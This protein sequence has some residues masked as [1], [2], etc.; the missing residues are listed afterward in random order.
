LS[1]I[2]HQ[3]ADVYAALCR[4]FPAV[5]ECKPLCKSAAAKLRHAAVELGLNKEAAYKIVR[6]HQTSPACLEA[7]LADGAIACSL[8]GTPIYQLTADEKQ[9]AKDRLEELAPARQKARQ[10][11]LHE[12]SRLKAERRK[13]HEAQTAAKQER[14]RLHEARAAAKQEW[15]RVPEAQA[16]VV[17]E[18]QV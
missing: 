10:S 15:R 6:A 18:G 2:P 12:A 3:Y 4:C 9:W 1:N 17:E 14:R 16:A 7:C 13:R 8:D 11:R 5:A